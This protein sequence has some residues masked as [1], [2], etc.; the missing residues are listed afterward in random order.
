[1]G[2][3]PE[4]CNGQDDDCNGTTDDGPTDPQLNQNCQLFKADNVTLVYPQD[5]PCETGTW[6]CSDVLH[7]LDCK[8]TVFPFAEVCDGTDNDCDGVIDGTTANPNSLVGLACT[9]NANGPC[10][11][12]GSGVST[13][14]NG[15]PGCNQ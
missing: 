4:I 12:V 8:Q 5:S 14:Q 1:V 2:Q 15:I 13:C 9:P 7:K 6:V 10:G 11:A 3:Y